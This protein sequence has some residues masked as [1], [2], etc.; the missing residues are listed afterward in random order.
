MIDY[1]AKPF[2][3]AKP[4]LKL[5]YIFKAT[6]FVSQRG[7]CPSS[8]S[9]SHLYIV[10]FAPILMRFFAFDGIF[11]GDFRKIGYGQVPNTPLYSKSQLTANNGLTWGMQ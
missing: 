4:S 2:R 3:L 8:P 7:A 1:M 10:V 9:P 6:R 11:H 5:V